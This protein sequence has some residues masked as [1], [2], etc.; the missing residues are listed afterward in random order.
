MTR[1]AGGKWAA[2]AVFATCVLPAWS[3]PPRQ[4]SMGVT[5]ASG[6]ATTVAATGRTAYALPLA[7]IKP[8][9][10][11]AF[12]VGNSFF[13]EN[14]V[15]A[16]A[17]AA[18]RDG[19]GPLFNARSCSA[20]HLFDGR[21]A[22]P[23]E[24]ESPVALILR[25]APHP[26]YGRQLQLAA[27]PG[28]TPEAVVTVG[29]QETEH[30]YPDGTPYSLQRPVFTVSAWH[31]GTSEPAPTLAPRLSPALVGGGLLEAVEVTTLEAWADESDADGDGISGRVARFRTAADGPEVVGR[32]GWKATQPD[33]A[34]QTAEALAQDMGLTSAIHAADNLTAEQ[35]LKATSFPSGG[36]NG[37]PEVSAVIFERM[38]TY[39]RALAPPARRQIHEP[40]V[41]RGQDLFHAISCAECHRNEMV[42]GPAAALDELARQTIAPYSDL[43]LHD[44]GPEL[45]DIAEG[46]ATAQE[47]RTP[48]LWGL[49]LLQTV[50]GH[51]RLLHDGRARDAEEAIL[52]HGGEAAQARDAF[53]ALP[54][55]ERDAV[56]AFLNSL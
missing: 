17:S 40:R 54:R 34:H 4:R 56:L 15:A 20:C 49:G 42:T 26:V 28:F 29:W 14:W 50:S 21:G 22:P 43:L 38:V 3:A 5:A 44:M 10:R 24:G 36:E 48:P 27:L 19:L 2:V 46:G 18:A 25:L 7:N 16:P 52:W 39:L 12:S 13:N 47:W 33:L 31:W 6:G 32:F 1:T 37:A 45:A 30:S 51:T 35:T 23:R 55:E 11:R 9:T 41:R 8:E 53:K